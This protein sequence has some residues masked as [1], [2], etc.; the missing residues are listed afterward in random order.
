MWE[1]WAIVQGVVEEQKQ[2]IMQQETAAPTS[3]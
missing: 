1:D 2:H 3:G